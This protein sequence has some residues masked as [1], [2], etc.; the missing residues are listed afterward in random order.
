[1]GLQS[2]ARCLQSIPGASSLPGLP[3]SSLLLSW[4]PSGSGL[5]MA[6]PCQEHVCVQ[7]GET[8]LRLSG[9]GAPRCS[10]GSPA[11]CCVAGVP[12]L[13][14]PTHWKHV[15]A[16][17][18]EQQEAASSMHLQA[19]EGP[20]WAGGGPHSE[21]RREPQGAEGFWEEE[22]ASA[23]A[24]G[25]QGALCWEESPY[26]WGLDREEMETSSTLMGGQRCLGVPLP[27]QLGTQ[28]RCWHGR[29][30]GDG[31]APLYPGTASVPSG[32][33][34][35]HLSPL[36]RA[37]TV[38]RSRGDCVQANPPGSRMQ[39]GR[40][41]VRGPSRSPGAVSQSGGCLAVRGAVPQSGGHLVVRGAVLQSGGCVSH[42]PGAVSARVGL[43]CSF[44]V[45]AVKSPALPINLPVPLPILARGRF[46]HLCS[47]G[48]T[49]D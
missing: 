39:G 10:K 44:S 20:G 25:H 45:V 35:C 18:T 30:C 9:R 28:W 12:C 8:V 3:R 7:G 38:G 13:H 29:S 21:A 1:M 42:S 37:D 40:P 47:G 24:Q 22:S 2:M 36:V 11:L 14:P 48:Q 31:D 43:S 27:G 15:A 34:P 26:L 19:P 49:L 32:H 16:S 46:K 41:A 17:G 33:V 4:G 5:E 6:H 23:A